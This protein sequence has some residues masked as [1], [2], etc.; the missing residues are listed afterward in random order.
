MKKKFTFHKR[1]SESN[2][3]F[4]SRKARLTFVAAFSTVKSFRSSRL[5]LANATCLQLLR[6][7]EGL[8][9]SIVSFGRFSPSQTFD[10]VAHLKAANTLNVLRCR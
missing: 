7:L 5:I 2:K 3:K 8:E 6:T 1:N 4:A 10:N 9:T